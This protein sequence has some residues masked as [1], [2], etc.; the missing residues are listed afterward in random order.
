MDG[1]KMKLKW[2]V[3]PA[4]TG[5]YRSF[6]KRDWPRAFFADE[7]IAFSIEC[8][9]SYDPKRV[10]DGDHEELKIW[11]ADWSDGSRSFTWK[12]IKQRAGTLAEAKQI[13]ADFLA[14]YSHMFVM[15]E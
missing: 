7:R 1:N 9:D 10:K 15:E 5:P 14:K 2:R 12:A 3:E 11:V 4:P 13:A 8:D 6:S